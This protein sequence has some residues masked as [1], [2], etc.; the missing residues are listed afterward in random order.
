MLFF[1]F[2]SLC[3]DT[4]I[5]A[6]SLLSHILRAKDHRRITEGSP[7]ES[8]RAGAAEY[9]TKESRRAGTAEYVTKERRCFYSIFSTAKVLYPV[10]ASQRSLFAKRILYSGRS[11]RVG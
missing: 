10:W 3:S 11:Y 2:Q 8:R 6:F 5:I 4:D 9:V 1:F 7:K